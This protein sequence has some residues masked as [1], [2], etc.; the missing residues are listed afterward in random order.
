MFVVAHCVRCFVWD[1][2]TLSNRPF[3]SLWLAKVLAVPA[4]LYSGQV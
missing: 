2:A 3:V 4:G 1:T